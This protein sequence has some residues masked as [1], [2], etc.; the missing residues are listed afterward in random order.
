MSSSVGD[1]TDEL[2]AEVSVFKIH[3]LRAKPFNMS[4]GVRHCIFKP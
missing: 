2:I 4:L 1:T 3:P